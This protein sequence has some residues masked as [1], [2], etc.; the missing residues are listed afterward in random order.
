MMVFNLPDKPWISFYLNLIK[1]KKGR[2][3]PV[4]CFVFFSSRVGAI[5]SPGTEIPK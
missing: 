5:N 1:K 3:A 2:I 4:F